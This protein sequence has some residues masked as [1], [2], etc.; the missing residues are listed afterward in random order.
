MS[1]VSVATGAPQRPVVELA[2]LRRRVTCLI[3]ESLPAFGVLVVGGLAPQVALSIGFKW[4]APGWLLWLHV[5]L[6]MGCYFV[7]VWRSNGQSLAMQ[8]W[9]LQIVDAASG[10]PA[11]LKQLVLRYVYAWPS[12]LLLLSGVGLIW[13]AWVDRDRQFPHDRWAGT[14]IV[15]VPRLKAG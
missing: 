10:R 5:F 9:S 14:C 2:S 6:L 15:L 8:T 7:A 11:S 12:L 1:A 4:A 13:T 3:Y